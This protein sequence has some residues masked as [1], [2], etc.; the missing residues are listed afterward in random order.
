MQINLICMWDFVCLFFFANRFGSVSQVDRLDAGDDVPIGPIWIF[1]R[2]TFRFDWNFFLK[3]WMK[4]TKCA[5]CEGGGA[6]VRVCLCLGRI[7]YLWQVNEVPPRA[8]ERNK[9]LWCSSY[10]W[11]P[12][13]R[14]HSYSLGA[15]RTR[16][17]LHTDTPTHTQKEK[18]DRRRTLHLISSMHT[19]KTSA[20]SEINQKKNNKKNSLCKWGNRL[21]DERDL[22]SITPTM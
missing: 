21:A 3:N 12:S 18:R 19:Q 16:T 10:R 22:A 4:R 6:C 15:I 9:K 5:P 14:E 17:H 11:R 20:P 1:T 7:V 2:E 13:V 8:K